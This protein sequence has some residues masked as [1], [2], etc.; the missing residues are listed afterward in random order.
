[1]KVDQY[2]CQT[3]KV[4]ET[5][6]AIENRTTTYLWAVSKDQLTFYRNFHRQYL[7]VPIDAIFRA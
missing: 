3:I 1:M 5:E 2:N 6:T 4:L 7:H